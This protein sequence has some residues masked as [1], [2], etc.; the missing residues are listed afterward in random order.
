MK[1][2]HID[3]FS[4]IGGF[5][6]AAKWVSTD[7]VPWETVCFVEIDKFC[8][9]ILAKHWPNV[10]CIND[11]N[12]VDGIV[13]VVGAYNGK[14]ISSNTDRN[15]LQKPWSEQQASRSGQLDENN[16][17]SAKGGDANESHGTRFILTGG[18]P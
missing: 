11:I 13:K 6:L 16:S 7:E 12:D 15:G 10:P 5:A 14:K 18:F 1:F 2:Y 4:G 17:N 8:K 3:T 9:Q